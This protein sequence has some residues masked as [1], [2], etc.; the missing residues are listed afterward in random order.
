MVSTSYLLDLFEY[1]GID[2]PST[3]I[4]TEHGEFQLSPNHLLR[5]HGC[6]DCGRT[7]AAKSNI[8]NKATVF[9]DKLSDEL[10]LS[11]FVYTR[12][13]HKSIVVCQTHGEYLMSPNSLLSGHRCPECAIGRIG[14]NSRRHVEGT[15]MLYYVH[16]P[17]INMWK[18]GVT[19]H[20]VKER[21]RKAEFETEVLHI[22]YYSNAMGAY[23]AEQLI[24]NT[25]IQF[26][27]KTQM[28]RDKG[29]PNVISDGN[30]ELF[31]ENILQEVLTCLEKNSLLGQLKVT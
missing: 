5:G 19:K 4:C 1:L 20:S 17:S 29:V 15:H 2:I 26:R 25:F 27:Y 23:L 13:N 11:K 28:L 7:K 6:P 31:T 3:V 14:W 18:I 30:Y 9:F 21:F 24:L 10:D 8:V 12:N 22:V 16:I